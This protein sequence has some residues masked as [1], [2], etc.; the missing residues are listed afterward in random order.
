MKKSV[1]RFSPTRAT[2]SLTKTTIG[3]DQIRPLKTFQQDAGATQ[4][5]ATIVSRR[6]SEVPMQDS[7]TSLHSSSTSSSNLRKAS[8]A[9][10]AHVPA[11]RVLR[12][13][14]KEIPISVPIPARRQEGERRGSRQDNYSAGYDRYDEDG[15]MGQSFITSSLE[16]LPNERHNDSPEPTQ[17]PIDSL[18]DAANETIDESDRL[19]C[20]N[21]GRKFAGED[22]LEKHAKACSKLK[23][24]KVFDTTKARTKGTELEQYVNRKPKVDGVKKEGDKPVKPAKSG[25]RVKHDNFIKMVRSNRGGGDAGGEPVS[26]EPDPDLVLW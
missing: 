14:V 23:P 25:W 9:A 8:E 5:T 19:P 26:Y 16:A 2:V 3:D 13:N 11:R 4:R 12:R 17:Y 22:R 15:K 18:D 1:K 7:T 24:R 6:L 20:P 21:C 10:E